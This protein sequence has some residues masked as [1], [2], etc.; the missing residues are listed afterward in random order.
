MPLK[1]LSLIEDCNCDKYI[2]IRNIT[3]TLPYV[4]IRMKQNT[5]HFKENM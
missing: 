1:P 2:L 4:Y 5:T 3:A